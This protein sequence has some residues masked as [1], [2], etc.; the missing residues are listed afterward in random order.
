MGELYTLEDYNAGTDTLGSWT[1]IAQAYDGNTATYASKSIATSTDDTTN[2][3][4]FTSRFD[5]CPNYQ[6]SKVEIGVF[7][8][9]S[10]STA[11][12]HFKIKVAGTTLS[13]TVHETA[14]SASGVWEWFDVTSDNAAPSP[15]T[16][17]DVDGLDIVLWGHNT[18][19]TDARIVYVG[20]VGVR[21]TVRSLYNYGND[22]A[23]HIAKLYLD[24]T[25]MPNC[26]GCSYDGT[27]PLFAEAWE[28]GTI[29]K[30]NFLLH[31][32]GTDNSTTITDEYG[33]TWACGGNAK[34]KTK[35]Y[36]GCLLHFNG[37][38][39]ST[40]FTEEYGHYFY[41]GNHTQLDTSNPKWG[42][43]SVKFDGTDDYMLSGDFNGLGDTWTVEGWFRTDNVN[44][45]TQGITLGTGVSVGGPSF[46]LAYNQGGDKKM[47]LFLSSDE[48][49]WD[50]A[51]GNAGAKTDWVNDTWYKWVLDF[52][53]SDY[54]VYI[55][56]SGALSED[57]KVT[58]STHTSTVGAI[59]L[60]AYG[61]TNFFLDGNIDEVRITTGTSRYG[62]SAS[63]EAGEFSTDTTSLYVSPKYG[64]AFAKFGGTVGGGWIQDTALAAGGVKFTL[65]GW[66]FS[67]NF[68][69]GQQTLIHCAY[70]SEGGAG[71]LLGFN[72]A[73]TKKLGI[74]LSSDG[75]WNIAANTEGTKTDYVK[76]TWYK[77]VID[78][79]GANYRVYVGASGALV[80]DIN[81]ADARAIVLSDLLVTTIGAYSS[82][83][84]YLYG[85]LDEVRMTFGKNLYGASA[86]AESRELGS[87]NESNLRFVAGGAGN[88]LLH[89]N[90]ANGS[91]TI[92]DEYGH[93]WAVSGSAV[94]NT[95]DK[96]FGSASLELPGATSDFAYTTDITS[97]GAKFTIEGWFHTDNVD[98]DSQAIFSAYN[99]SNAGLVLWYHGSTKILYLLA[100]SDGASWDIA[101]WVANSKRDWVNDT[102]YN[103]V[104]DFDGSTYR[105]YIGT[106]GTLVLDISVT[107]SSVICAVTY[108]V[109]GC[110]MGA[111]ALNGGVDEVRMLIGRNRYGA[112]PPIAQTA[113][114]SVINAVLV[115]RA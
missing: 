85:G 34:L 82:T 102:W 57:I 49:T 3:I 29:A 51:N 45:G 26:L 32:N 99:G 71:I 76:E 80:E 14:Y 106:S 46:Y 11:H 20:E 24:N 9:E 56:T 7:H 5:V 65:E 39:T 92:T 19:G 33:H 48:A 10:G 6:I 59:W 1:S 15:W 38:N 60:G 103:W 28:V 79:D 50:I 73:G 100:S 62:G 47:N 91:T 93:T 36:T 61:T 87:S 105:V 66:F 74:W 64:T 96:K 17:G 44:T 110:Y 16:D 4:V 52:D 70:S 111:Y 114:F 67:T 43:A 112:L 31:L 107:S 90:G 42:S 41:G 104:I 37:T 30:R 86:F 108:V 53:G 27:N 113:E 58:S 83:G 77:W 35:W 78:Y 94:L 25:A 75:T 81:I 101:N 8:Y 84:Y 98:T 95:G 21:I 55:G 40:V 63:A 22:S 12:E 115:G 54:R 88:A 13:T 68:G 97:L 72:W 69:A 18:S 23:T 89:L 109:L 2:T